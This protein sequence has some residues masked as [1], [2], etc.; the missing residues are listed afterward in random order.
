MLG[1]TPCQ[2][3][4]AGGRRVNGARPGCHH[5]GARSAARAGRSGDAATNRLNAPAGGLDRPV[6]QLLAGI[7]HCLSVALPCH[8][9]CLARHG[10]GTAFARALQLPL[11][12]PTQHRHPVHV[13]VQCLC[14]TRPKPP[15]VYRCQVLSVL[16][17]LAIAAV[18]FVADSLLALTDGGGSQNAVR[19]CL[20]FCRTTRSPKNLPQG[21]SVG[22]G[23]IFRQSVNVTRTCCACPQAARPPPPAARVHGASSAGSTGA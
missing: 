6:L 12:V 16:L 21:V 20:P 22:K 8:F 19:F 1:A 9:L 11:P 17:P 10:I 4:R 18:V 13:S 23:E 5:G 14:M 3:R 15:A 7:G 2:W